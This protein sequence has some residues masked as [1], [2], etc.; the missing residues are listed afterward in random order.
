MASPLSEILAALVSG[1][2]ALAV[3]V[4]AWAVNRK[5]LQNEITH[6]R[7]QNLKLTDALHL[8]MYGHGRVEEKP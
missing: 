4:I 3:A 5:D 8:A 7:E 2:P 1:I 6:L